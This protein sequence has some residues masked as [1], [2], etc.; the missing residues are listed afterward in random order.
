MEIR[1]SRISPKRNHMKRI[2]TVIAALLVAGLV[3]LHAQA[4]KNIP[5]PPP[6]P[7]IPRVDISNFEAPLPPLE[8]YK[9]NPSVAIVHWKNEYKL[10]LRLKDGK[11]ENYD[12]NNE[13]E[14]KL[15]I[16]KYGAVPEPPPPP[17]PP[18]PP[19]PPP[20]PQKS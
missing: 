3:S 20:P 19:S 9:R 6:P 4:D 11:T 10:E 2:P 7:P 18:L 14:R 17:P 12:L 16:S 13:N 15:F 5:P 8:F 1:E